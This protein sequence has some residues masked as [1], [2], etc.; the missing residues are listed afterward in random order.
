MNLQEEI[1]QIVVAAKNA[2]PVLAVAQRA[3]KDAALNF[4]AEEIIKNKQKILQ[5]N[6]Q[7]LESLNCS[8]PA[9][10]RERMTLTAARIDAMAESL[11]QIAT[12]EDTVGK[13]LKSW[14]AP[15]GFKIERVS[16]PLGVLC[17]IYESRP[18]VTA[19]AAALCI[20][21]GNAVILRGGAD[22]FNSSYAIWQCLQE[23]L[24][25][26]GLP[27]E[28]AQM[29]PSKSRDAVGEL[30]KLDDLIDV[31]IP[32]GGKSLI[33]RVS[34]ETRIPTFKHLNGICHTFVEKN[35]D[36]DMAAKVVVNAKMRRTSICGAT[37]TLLLD[38]ALPED[39]AK[40]IIDALIASGCEV[41]GDAFVQKLNPKVKPAAPTDFGTEFLDA[42]I[43]AKQVDGVKGAAEHIAKY[44]SSHTE[45]IITSD[46]KAAEEFLNSVDSAV[47]MHNAS[48]QFCDG[49]EF[50]F[51]G[52]IGIATGRLHARGPV[53]LEQLTTFKYKVK[54]EGHI[55][56]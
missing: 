17:V 41:R 43:S 46:A 5:A 38:K 24:K 36:I 2:F 31:I 34:K 3:Q 1:R 26:A 30:L 32:R 9:P 10:V 13:I 8:V 44:G 21:S 12:L 27:P 40:K 49:G 55:R 19:D 42:I 47:V 37:E 39:S 4:A 33:E 50:G 35:A 28:C 48:T 20:K 45:S 14:T 15:A 11:K 51:G 6:E 56:K 25:R 54:G 16:V 29:V 18:N 7:D 22:A 52:E 53:A 23:G